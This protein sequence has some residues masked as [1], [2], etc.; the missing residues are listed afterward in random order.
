MPEENSADPL[1]VYLQAPDA[2]TEAGL[3]RFMESEE[4]LSLVEWDGNTRVDVNV[5]ALD[6]V[7]DRALR[8][9]G[10][11]PCSDAPFLLVVEEKW[12][13]DVPA[14]VQRGVRA[15]LDRAD[16]SAETLV[17]TLL[18]LGR[19]GGALPPTLQGELLDR[20]RRAD[21]GDP[22]APELDERETDILRLLSE[23]WCLPEIS[24]KVC[25]SERTVKNILYA[26]MGRLG[27]RSRTQAVAWAIRA[28]L[29]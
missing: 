11:L 8:K 7:D 28:G 27:C 20:I 17:R 14:A 25:Y 26:L 21:H 23:G 19:G 13:A 1:R 18:T 12:R 15:V 4:R 10:A 5:V 29:I 16:C 22:V 2:I 6:T 3:R 9:L 24:E